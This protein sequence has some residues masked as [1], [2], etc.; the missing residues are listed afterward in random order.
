D[1]FSKF[2]CNYS[3]RTSLAVQH[4]RGPR[5]STLRQQVAIY[6]QE[7]VKQQSHHQQREQSADSGKPDLQMLPRKSW[8]VKRHSNNSVVNS[9]LTEPFNAAYYGFANGRVGEVNPSDLFLQTDT[10]NVRLHQQNDLSTTLGSGH[11]MNPLGHSSAFDMFGAFG[12]PITDP[13]CSMLGP[14]PFHGLNR[15]IEAQKF[16]DNSDF[17]CTSTNSVVTGRLPALPI[18]QN[19]GPTNFQERSTRDEAPLNPELPR[20]ADLNGTALTSASTWTKALEFARFH[21][22][23]LFPIASAL[24]TSTGTVLDTGPNI[25]EVTSKSSTPSFCSP[26]MFGSITSGQFN[27]NSFIP[28]A[29]SIGSRASMMNCTK[30]NPEADTLPNNSSQFSTFCLQSY[31]TRLMEMGLSQTSSFGWSEFLPFKSLMPP[32]PPFAPRSISPKHVVHS[33]SSPAVDSITTMNVVTGAPLFVQG[34][35]QNGSTAS[36]EISSNAYTN[37]TGG[38]SVSTADSLTPS[39]FAHQQIFQ[40]IMWL[41]TRRPDIQLS[42]ANNGKLRM[43]TEQLSALVI[44]R[45]NALYCLTAMEQVYTRAQNPNSM[46][47]SDA[48]VKLTEQLQTIWS[49]LMLP[50]PTTVEGTMDRETDMTNRGLDTQTLPAD[51]PFRPLLSQL[52]MLRLRID[53]FEWLRMLALVEPQRRNLTARSEPYEA[54]SS[55]VLEDLHE[56][57]V[58]LYDQ[59]HPD[60]AGRREQ[61]TMF[62]SMLHLVMQACHHR[63]PDW[64]ERYFRTTLD[65]P[66]R[67]MTPFI[68]NMLTAALGVTGRSGSFGPADKSP[69]IRSSK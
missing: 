40:L 31:L 34:S 18:P 6:L 29:T 21:F 49:R 17:V 11:F 10:N 9:S 7:R 44:D 45:W 53:E 4:E 43:S 57:V 65:P 20:A 35:E 23:Q 33:N 24:P 3:T 36:P 56:E 55:R 12:N 63:D 8:S 51:H 39:A 66:V 25:A 61:L 68:Q 30:L 54:V 28:C 46:H 38:F 16:T 47:G 22:P 27:P 50:S 26:G 67:H 37:E 59:Q 58:R 42:A 60:N 1:Q 14:D 48:Y 2:L 13:N 69:T 19:F 52:A 5:N 62:L 41:S 64:M 15:L 32:V